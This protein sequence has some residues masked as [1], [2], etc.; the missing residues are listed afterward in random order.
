[1]KIRSYEKIREA[2]REIDP[3][4]YGSLSIIRLPAGRG[5]DGTLYS[6]LTLDEFVEQSA[7]TFTASDLENVTIMQPNR[8]LTIIDQT[9]KTGVKASVEATGDPQKVNYESVS[10]IPVNDIVESETLK[11]KNPEGVAKLRNVVAKTGFIT[12]L[13]LNTDLEVIDGYL[14][15]EVARVEKLS[16]V[17]AVIVDADERLSIF[18]RLVLNR[19]SEF[20]RWDFEAVDAFADENL[21][22]TGYLEPYG[23][24]S[25]NIVPKTFLGDTVKNY[26]ISEHNDQQ[27]FYTQS[28]GLAEWARRMRKKAVDLEAAKKPQK[29]NEKNSV[30]R[31]FLQIEDDSTGAAND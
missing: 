29:A 11:R 26:E 23:I 21:N 24:F 15:L 28:V 5:L 25:S 3:N 12:P 17:P 20:Q 7:G 16:S 4:A 18:L 14:R 30:A 8:G 6:H 2:I 22:M 19:S 13:I 1:M 9:K 27:K 31:F 10:S